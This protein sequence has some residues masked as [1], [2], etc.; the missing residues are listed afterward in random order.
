MTRQ[1]MLTD[2]ANVLASYSYSDVLYAMKQDAIV[3]LKGITDPETGNALN[4]V[5]DALAKAEQVATWNAE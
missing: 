2:I 5:R 4:A 3:R 1:Q